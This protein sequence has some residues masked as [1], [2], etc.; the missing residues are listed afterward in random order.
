MSF[1]FPEYLEFK[2]KYDETIQNDLHQGDLTG[3]DRNASGTA[4]P[5]EWRLLHDFLFSANEQEKLF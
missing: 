4:S 5:K 3:I 2:S 1:C